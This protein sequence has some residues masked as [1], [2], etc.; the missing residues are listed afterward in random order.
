MLVF[1]VSETIC[2]FNAHAFKLYHRGDEEL[3]VSSKNLIRKPHF[4][5][6]V[7]MAR[8]SQWYNIQLV[9]NCLYDKI[10]TNCTSGCEGIF[11]ARAEDEKF[12][13]KATKYLLFLLT[14]G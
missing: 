7:A 10:R 13:V 6:S 11:G 12:Y 9:S 5:S 8:D 4:Q 2:Q 1:I 3:H 14:F